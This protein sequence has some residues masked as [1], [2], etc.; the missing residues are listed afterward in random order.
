MVFVRSVNYRKVKSRNI[1]SSFCLLKAGNGFE[2]FNV[3][4]TG[5]YIEW[6]DKPCSFL[7]ATTDILFICCR[8]ARCHDP[9]AVTPVPHLLCRKASHGLNLTQRKK[10]LQLFH[11]N[12]LLVLISRKQYIFTSYKLHLCHF[13]ERYYYYLFV[14]AGDGSTVVVAPFF[15][16]TSTF[17]VT[18]GKINPCSIR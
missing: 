13:T 16:F 17:H 6:L 1:I 18:G 14:I 5:S 10:S 15:G 7:I 3:S 11:R 9:E 2:S 8:A 12:R 4:D